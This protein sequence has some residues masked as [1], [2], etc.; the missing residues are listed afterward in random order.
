MASVTTSLDGAANGTTAGSSRTDTVTGDSSSHTVAYF[1]TDVVGNVSGTTTQTIKI[2][3]TA[4][5]AATGLSGVTGT[6]SGTVVLS[7]TAGTDALSGVSGYTIQRS[8]VVA[9]CP[10]ANTTNYPNAT[11][12]GAVTTATVG[13][14]VSNSKYCFYLTTTD[15]AGNVSVASAAAGPTKAK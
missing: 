2:D 6:T 8:G 12:V 5:T 7:W 4:P 9:S 15:N 13:G 10:A 1:G 3:T 11:T 14:M